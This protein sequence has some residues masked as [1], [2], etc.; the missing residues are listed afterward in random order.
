MPVAILGALPYLTSFLRQ[1]SSSD[2]S[3]T[4]LANPSKLAVN[5]LPRYYHTC[6]SGHQI[7]GVLIVLRTGEL[8][9]PKHIQTT[10]QMSYMSTK[11][12]I[13]RISCSIVYHLL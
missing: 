1:Y 10:P 2:R 6:T 7:L 12:Y 9:G 5:L 3:N 13:S 8:A 4:V 11:Y